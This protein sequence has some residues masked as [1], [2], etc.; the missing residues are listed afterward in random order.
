MRHASFVS[1]R[2]GSRVSTSDTSRVIAFGFPSRP[3]VLA[4]FANDCD[5]YELSDAR[6]DFQVFPRALFPYHAS[7]LE[8]PVARL[9]RGRETVF[10]EAATVGWSASRVGFDVVIADRTEGSAEL[11]GD[12]LAPCIS[13][14]TTDVIP[15]AIGNKESQSVSRAMPHGISGDLEWQCSTP[16]V[17]FFF[18]RHGTT[19]TATH[20][21]S[22]RIHFRHSLSNASG[23]SI[24]PVSRVKTSHASR[25][26]RADPLPGTH[27]HV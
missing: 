16:G 5:R 9:S 27:A 4:P 20:S 23:V 14:E 25:V 10:V 11:A 19:C 13:C 17:E 21:P 22:T 24:R 15:G 18:E 7:P 8:Y 2:P 26:A 6:E 3:F 12:V 1:M